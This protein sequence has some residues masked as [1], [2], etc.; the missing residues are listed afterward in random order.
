[1]SQSWYTGNMIR[2]ELNKIIKGDVEFNEATLQKYSHDAS[3]L[4]IK[5]E[6]VVFPKNTE[7]VKNLVKFVRRKKEQGENV[8]LAPRSAGTDM[9]GGPLTEKIVVE[10][11]RYFNRIKEVGEGYAITE[12]GVYYRDFEKETLKKGY[13]LPSY[14]ASREICAVGG[15][16]AN[17]SGGEK[18]LK[19]GKTENYILELKAVFSDG[20]E[21]IIKPLNDTEM[22]DKM[23]LQNFEGEFYRKMYSLAIENYELLKDAKPKVSKNSAGYYLW[24][25]YDKEKGVFDLTKLFTGSQGT[26]GIITEI[27]F[28]LVKPEPYSGLLVI[29]M[30]DLKEVGVIVNEVLMFKPTSFESFDD[31]TFKLA[32]KYFADFLKKMFAKNIIHLALKFLPEFFLMVTYGIPKLVLL[33]EFEEKEQGIVEKKIKELKNKLGKFKVKMKVAR[34]KGEAQKYWLMRRESFNLLREKVKDKKTAP[35]ID[36][37]IVKPEKLPEFLPKLYEILDKYELLYTVAGHAGDGNFHII[38]LMNLVEE[39]ERE[40]IP[41][42]AEEVY[43]LVLNFDGSITAEHND[44][45]IRSPYLKQMYGE[46]VYELFEETKKIFDPLNIF[47][48]G[49]KVGANW[50]Y[51]MEHIRKI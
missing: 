21:Y 40:K 3:F 36:D 35:F 30:K 31:H 9:T 50:E 45:L 1:M 11:T 38:P 8:S 29:F 27:K 34:T 23:K 49:K 33:A 2:D 4:E 42:V 13:F 25:V 44:G 14:P 41:K 5:P 10:F 18:N 46:K 39:K 6:V 7:D 16:V 43:K 37:V 28:R 48:P 17:N 19:Y 51:A 20:E 24:N 12:P 22:T 26:L 32:M 47:N 15:M